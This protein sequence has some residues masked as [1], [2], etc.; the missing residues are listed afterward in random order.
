MD[1]AK[2]R[3]WEGYPLTL[4]KDRYTGVYSG[5]EWIAFALEPHEVPA[6]P[7]GGDVT[8]ASYWGSGEVLKGG[9][10]PQDQPRNPRFVGRGGTPEAAMSDLG[11][12]MKA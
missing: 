2:A 7:W 9:V 3:G 11:T 1:K 8:A 5:G 12:R 10:L 6:E 4:A